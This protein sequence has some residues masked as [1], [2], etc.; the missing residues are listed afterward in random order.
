MKKRSSRKYFSFNFSFF[1]YSSNCPWSLTSRTSSCSSN[2]NAYSKID[3]YYYQG[4]EREGQRFVCLGCLEGHMSKILKRGPGGEG[5]NGWKDLARALKKR[6]PGD[7]W[8]GG[9][10]VI[11]PRQP[12][13]WKKVSPRRPGEGGYKTHTTNIEQLSISYKCSEWA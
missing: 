7:Q 1:Y 6:V 13:Q 2:V 4:G 11:R 10:R 8:E 12:T 9:R 5:R 3:Y